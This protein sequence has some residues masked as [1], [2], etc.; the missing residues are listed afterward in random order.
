MS[1]QVPHIVG[2]D[3][4]VLEDSESEQDD[5]ENSNE[6]EM[7]MDGSCWVLKANHMKPTPPISEMKKSPVIPKDIST[8]PTKAFLT[9]QRPQPY[10]LAIPHRLVN[11]LADFSAPESIGAR[12]SRRSRSNIGFINDGITTQI[13]PPVQLAKPMDITGYFHELSVNLVQQRVCLKPFLELR[14][15]IDRLAAQSLQ[16]SKRMQK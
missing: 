14:K 4:D 3:D 10:S 6:N 11:S 16:E 9:P 12:V 7:A 8:V 15:R 13:A 1:L 2:D 5:K